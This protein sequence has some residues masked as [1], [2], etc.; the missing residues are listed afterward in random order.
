MDKESP[1]PPKAGAAASSFS[2]KTNGMEI[3]SA[4]KASDMRGAMHASPSAMT[5]LQF[6]SCKERTFLGEH[7]QLP[8]VWRLEDC[9]DVYSDRMIECQTSHFSCERRSLSQG[10]LQRFSS[11]IK[12][13][14]TILCISLQPRNQSLNT[15]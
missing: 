3:R 15:T 2:E 10:S 11:A 7:S 5:W 13:L 4:S 6:F 14:L 1:P 8:F 12:E 9:M